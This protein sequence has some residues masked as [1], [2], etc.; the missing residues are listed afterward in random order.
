MAISKLSTELLQN[1]YE[2]SDLIDILHLSQTSKQNYNALHGRYMPIVRRALEDAYGPVPTL[3]RLVISEDRTKTKGSISTET[4]RNATLDRMLSVPDEPVLSK[5]LLNKM[6][7]FGSVATKWVE[8]FPQFRWRDDYRNRRFLRPHEQHRLRRA[9]YNYWIYNILFHDELFTHFYPDPPIHFDYLSVT[10]FPH[11]MLHPS[12]HIDHRLR[13]MQSFTTIELVQLR[14]FLQCVVKLI[15]IDLYPSNATVQAHHNFTAQAVEKIAWGGGFDYLYL[16]K[17]LLKYSPSDL[18]YLYDQTF[19]KLERAGYMLSQGLSFRDS[20]GTMD[21]AITCIIDKRRR[22][23]L[24][25]NDASD[26]SPYITHRFPQVEYHSHDTCVRGDN[27]KFGIADEGEESYS[28]DH[29]F[30]NDGTVLLSCDMG[31]GKPV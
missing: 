5:Q 25:S 8:I 12:G 20:R 15:E 14:E 16:V 1:I 9:I 21:K 22:V 18:Y 23:E 11:S 10:T 6:I 30:N 7:F 31:Y 13:L 29:L 4:R 2:H 19:T 28:D 3:V 26:S 24:E 17:D 27:L